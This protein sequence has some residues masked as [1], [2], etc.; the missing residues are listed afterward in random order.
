MRRPRK[1]VRTGSFGRRLAFSFALVAVVTALLAGAIL[2]LA[3]AYQFDRYVTDNLTETANR[4][5]AILS[6][7]YSEYGQWEARVFDQMLHFSIMSGFALQV[8]DSLGEPLYDDRAFV[9]Q[10]Y[11]QAAQ[12]ATV[13]EAKLP[14][15]PVVKVPIVVGDQVVGDVHMWSLG[16]DTLLT[17]N[18]LRFRR[19]AL[20]ALAAAALLAALLATTAGLLYARRFVRPISRITDT[21]EALRA[22]DR[23]ARTGMQGADEIGLLGRTLDEMADAIEADRELERRLT[24][25]VAHELRTPLQAIQATVEAMQD[26]VLPMDEE[27]L[28]IVRDETV[29]LAR[30]ADG[31]LEL[32]RLERGSIPMRMVRVDLG[33]LAGAVVESHRALV[34]SSDLVLSL[35]LAEGVWVDGDP[36]RLRQ[37]LGNLLS[38]AARYTPAGGRVTVAVRSDGEQAIVEVSDTGVG[39]AEDDLENVFQR[40][41]RAGSARDRASGGLGIGL[42][43]VKEILERHKGSVGVSRR[44]EGGTT[45]TLRLPRAGTSSS[46]ASGAPKGEGRA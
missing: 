42:A 5:A 28:S 8:T 37:A 17:D 33:E 29:R 11:G 10:F 30:L 27:R 18:D 12:G 38:N 46:V 22:G 20:Y 25:D 7:R 9:A 41:W 26:G 31:I 43:V 40:F 16:Q 14:G 19:S 4:A 13:D 32:T 15:A 6:S 23:D 44:T 3:W 34:E 21:A 24:A 2:S 39:I 1:A 45:F 36:D 35:D